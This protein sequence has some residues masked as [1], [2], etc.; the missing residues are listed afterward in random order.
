VIASTAA[1]APPLTAAAPPV[2]NMCSHGR[3]MP[4]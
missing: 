1:D 4:V 2:W 3:R